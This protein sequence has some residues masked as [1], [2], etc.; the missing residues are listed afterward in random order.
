METRVPFRFVYT[1]PILAFMFSSAVA[2]QQTDFEKQVSA[3]KGALERKQYAQAMEFF[4]QGQKVANRAGDREWEANFSFYMGLTR[5]GQ[6]GEAGNQSEAKNLLQDAETFYRRV[7]EVLPHSGPALNNLAQIY[8]ETGRTA[9][10]EELYQ[11]LI[12]S[13]SPHQ[14]FYRKNYAELLSRK[15]DWRAAVDNYKA[16][17]QAQPE[18]VQAYQ[19]AIQFYLSNEQA[20][21]AEY[22]WE[23]L[24]KDLAIRALESALTFLEKG[25]WSKA[26][27]EDLLTVVAVSLSRQYYD[28]VKFRDSPSAKRLGAL[29]RNPLIGEGA[30]R[31]VDLH[32]EERFDPIRYAWW[33]ERGSTS[34]DKPRGLWPRD[35]FRLLIRSLGNWFYKKG[36]DSRAEQYYRLAMLL[37]RREPDPEAFLDLVDLYIAKN[38]ITEIDRLGQEVIPELFYGKGL[39]YRYSQLQKVYKYHRALGVVY[40]S[41]ERWGDVGQPASAIFQL[42]HARSVAREFNAES[43]RKGSKDRLSIEPRLIDLLAKGYMRVDHPAASVKVRIDAAEEY[44]KESNPENARKVLQ[45]VNNQLPASISKQD[46]DRYLKI[47]EQLPKNPRTQ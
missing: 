8:S 36:S 7:L 21:P 39:A 33:G 9:E 20:D 2:A 6:A 22:L 42:E 30:I 4:S 47:M 43:A 32:A 38:R 3:G 37:S 23:L 19:S 15:G 5:Q 24:N 16:A 34:A 28:P 17:V 31:I 41:L 44:V 13:N 12:E 26:V 27:N 14:A 25:R 1:V 18:N 35:G 40:S 45:P 46:K 10:A 11:R 29:E